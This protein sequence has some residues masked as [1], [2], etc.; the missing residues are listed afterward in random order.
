MRTARFPRF[1]QTA[2]S[3]YARSLEL[4]PPVQ[5]KRHEKL[6][7]TVTD[8]AVYAFI[9][10]MGAFQLTH[11][12]HTPDFM[13]DVTYPDLARS[14]LE[15]GSYQIRLLPE[16]T[17][18]PGLPLILAAVGLFFGLT[19]ATLFPVIT[20]SATLGL[21]ATYEFLR[22]VEGR[23]VAAAISLFF[24]SCPALFSFGTSTIYP[25]IPYFL[26]SMLALLIALKI[27]HAQRRR[28]LIVSVVFLSITLVAAV[29]IR[30]AGVA[31]L[32]GL[33]AWVGTSQLIVPGIGR[34]RLRRFVVP[35]VIGLTVQLCWSVWAHRRENF[36][37]QLPGYPRSY[38]SQLRVK[39]GHHPELGEVHLGDIPARIGRNLVARAAGF[40]HLLT[41][42]NVSKV[43]SSPL[44]FGALV[45][46][47]IGAASSIW[48]G[49]GQLHDWYFLCYEFI[50]M[51]W[52]WDYRDRFLIPVVPLACLYLWR[53]VKAVKNYAVRQPRA[54]GESFILL[55][56]LLCISSAAF[57]FGI[58]AF[59]ANPEHVRG[60]RLQTIAATLFWGIFTAMGLWML[61]RPSLE[62]LRDSTGVFSRLSQIVESRGPAGLRVAAT[63]IVAAIVL[64]G[65]VRV[66]TIGRYNV[67]HD[68]TEDSNYPM[69]KAT[70]WI[71]AHEP[72]D[73]VIM[74]SEPEFV[75][76]YSHHQ[77][78]WFPPI[79]D[80]KTLMDGIQRHHIG[81]ILV[82]HQAQS[83]W[84]PPED[85]CFQ[86]LLQAYPGTFKLAHRDLN[87][88]VY[89]VASP[90]D[91][92]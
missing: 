36:E 64:L 72:S 57:S 32:A 59:P 63:V 65:T 86:A 50:F 54:A 22:R 79:S 66:M 33:A 47:A 35:L 6:R 23:G 55:G 26:V 68:I 78:V 17:F 40:S 90:Y 80:P 16:T 48:A 8:V 84:L 76:H 58:A 52:P 37:W 88:W 62:R 69:L 51:V 82:V 49:A 15:H 43:W 41:Q 61:K 19:P 60:D 34:R 87:T 89:E 75:F 7:R 39:N 14:I 20:V 44:I 56:S 42:R 85:V 4:L 67:R 18:P 46:I 83:Y 70:E 28:S 31:L 24:A 1:A 25:E 45:L 92:R 38:V 5:S 29:L 27:D 91:G 13:N 71:D 81:A 12:L 2:S 10:L 30:S 9:L 11:Y 77:T 74:A 21:I 73:R 53:G 3:E